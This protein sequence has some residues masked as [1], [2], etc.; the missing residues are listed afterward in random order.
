MAQRITPAQIR[1]AMRS[2]GRHQ[3]DMPRTGNGWTGGPKPTEVIFRTP[4][5]TQVDRIGRWMPRLRWPGR[6]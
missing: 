2:G 4:G 5:G 3:A 6:S 1:R